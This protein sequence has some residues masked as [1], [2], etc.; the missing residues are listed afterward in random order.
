[1][2][3]RSELA[4]FCLLRQSHTGS[5]TRCHGATKLSGARAVRE[6]FATNDDMVEA[7]K[8]VIDD[9]KKPARKAT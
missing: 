2:R 4:T 8:A 5:S 6:T 7:L 9:L 1:M 3:A